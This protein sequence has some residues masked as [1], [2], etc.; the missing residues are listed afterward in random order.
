M[1]RSKP[2]NPL[3]H[4]PEAVAW[5][6]GRSGLTQAMLAEAIGISISHMSEIEKGSRN[7]P[8]PLLFKIATALNCP[9][10]FLERKRD[11]GGPCEITD[12]MP[13]V[14]NGNAA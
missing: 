5:A 14:P 9:I 2:K 13:D 6:R 7:A 11:V 12:L 3:D 10:V 1:P 4:E 8:P